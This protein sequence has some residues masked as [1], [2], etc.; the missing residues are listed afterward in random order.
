MKYRIREVRQI[1]LENR[2]RIVLDGWG[3]RTERSDYEERKGIQ[4]RK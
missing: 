4:G 1:E 3:I 2:N